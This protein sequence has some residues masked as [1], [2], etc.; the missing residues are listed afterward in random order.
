MRSFLTGPTMP[1]AL[2]AEN[3]ERCHARVFGDVAPDRMGG[4]DHARRPGGVVDQARRLCRLRKFPV[5][6]FVTRCFEVFVSHDGDD[7]RRR[8]SIKR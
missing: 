7:S 5:P 8:R 4:A 1:A 3:R 6:R 2:I